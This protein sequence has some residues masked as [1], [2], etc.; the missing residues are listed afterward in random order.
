MEFFD[1]IKPPKYHGLRDYHLRSALTTSNLSLKNVQKWEARVIS[2]ITLLNENFKITERDPNRVLGEILAKSPLSSSYGSELYHAGRALRLESKVYPT[3]EAPLFDAAGKMLMSDK[4]MTKYYLTS[5][6]F[7]RAIVIANAQQANKELPHTVKLSKSDE[8]IGFVTQRLESLDITLKLGAEC[9]GVIMDN[10]ELSIH[11]IDHLKNW[12]DKFTERFNIELACIFGNKLNSSIYPPVDLIYRFWN[13]WDDRLRNF[14]NRMYKCVKIFEALVIGTI[15]Y[16]NPNEVIKTP[17]SF[18]ENTIKDFGDSLSADQTQLIEPVLVMRDLLMSISSMQYLSQL[19]GLYRTW[20]HPIVNPSA[21]IEKVMT[22]GTKVKTISSV[23]PKQI[24]RVFMLKYALWFKRTKSAYPIFSLKE[25]EDN[26]N[27]VYS[28]LISDAPTAMLEATINS[29]FW[30]SLKFEKNIEIPKTYNLSEMVA[31]KAV[32]PNRSGLFKLCNRRGGLYDANMR[33]GVLQWL[34]QEPEACEVFLKRVNDHSLTND[35]C[36]IGLYQKEREENET[37]R[38]FALMS[39]SIRNYIVTSES[40]L[41]EDI[42][43]A[44]PSIT[45]TNSLLDLQKKIYSISH[46]QSLNSSNI[47]FNTYK[48]VTVIVNIDFEKWNLNF[49]RE[50]TFPLFEALGDLYGLPNLYNRTYDIFENSL[51][52][53]A[54]GSY[55]PKINLQTESII[56]EPPLSYIGHLG[57]LE[58][59]RQKGW[60]LFTDC[61]LE[62][63]CVRHKCKYIIMGQGDNQVLA[64]TW[65]TYMLDGNREVNEKGKQSIT[66]QFNNFMSD[67]IETFALLG[68]PIKALETWS[69]EHLF[70]YGKFP[71]LKGIPLSMSLKKICRAY[72]LANEEIMTLDCSL[73]TIQSNAMAACMSDV[74]SY[75]PYVVYKVQTMLAIKSFWD[76]HV[77]LGQGAFNFESGDKWRFTTSSGTKYQYPLDN[78]LNKWDFMIVLSWF[79]KILGGLSVASWFDFLLRGFP[80]RVTSSLTW[81]RSLL[82]SISDIK[83]KETLRSV[84]QTQLNPEKNYTLLIEDPCAL[85][86]VVPVDARASVKQAVQELFDNMQEV[87]NEEFLS[88]FRF[89]K[90]WAKEDFCSALCEGVILHPR[91]LHDVAAATLGGYVDGIVSKVSKASTINKLALRS[92]GRDPGRK[93]VE[94]ERNYML[95]LLWKTSP[96]NSCRSGIEFDCPTR[97]ARE[98][99][100]RSWDKILEGVTVPHPLAFLEFRDCSNNPISFD[101]CDRNYIMVTL[102]EAFCFGDL[103]TVHNLGASPP[104][105]GSETKEK[106]GADPSRQVFGKE[107]LIHRPLRLL[108]VINW[109]VR[110]KSNAE[111][112]IYKL[113]ESVSSLDPENYVSKEMGIT[114]SEAHR[115]RDQ[116]LKH[117]V[118][119]ANMYTLGSHMHIS[120]DTWVKYTRGALNFTINYQSI[121]V[122]V[123]ALIGGHIFNCHD[124]HLI[125]AREYHFHEC[126]TECIEPLSDEFH[127]LPSDKVLSLIPSGFGN[128]YLWVEEASLTLKYRTDPILNLQI[129]EVCYEEYLSYSNKREILTQWVG[130]SIVNDILSGS[131]QDYGPR[132]LDS[133]DYPRVMYKKL[134]VKELWEATALILIAK[135]GVKY[136][137]STGSRVT[138]PKSARELAA[139]DLMKCSSTSLMGLAMFYTWPDKFSEISAYDS[140]AIYPNTCPPTIQSAC[141]AVQANMRNVLRKAPLIAPETLFL[142]RTDKNPSLTIKVFWYIILCSERN[143]CTHCIKDMCSLEIDNLQLMSANVK[144]SMGHEIITR[145]MRSIKV[146]T[147]SLDRVL[148]DSVAFSINNIQKSN[149]VEVMKCPAYVEWGT[150]QELSV[151][152]FSMNRPENPVRNITW[153]YS[154]LL[155]TNSKCRTYEILSMIEENTDFSISSN[156]LILGDGLGTTSRILSNL[157]PDT[158]WVV[159][160]L[161]DSERTIPQCF[162]HVLIPENP[163]PLP[164]VNYSISKMRYNDLSSPGFA[165][166]WSDWIRGGTCWSDIETQDD[167]RLIVENLISLSDWDW[168]IFRSDYKSYAEAS[169]ILQTLSRHSSRVWLFISGSLDV[170][171]LESV[172][173]CKGCT[174]QQRNEIIIYPNAYEDCYTMSCMEL[175]EKAGSLNYAEYLAS[176]ESLEEV[177]GMIHRCDQWFSAVGITHLLS[178]NRLFTAMWWDLQT[179]KIPMSV[180]NLGANKAYYLYFSDLIAL[181]SRLLSLAISMIKSNKKMAEEMTKIAFWK[182]TLSE[183]QNGSVSFVLSRNTTPTDYGPDNLLMMKFVPIL[184]KLNHYHNRWW[185]TVPNEIRFHSNHSMPGFWISKISQNVPVTLP[186]IL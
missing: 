97:Q 75:V 121:L 46:K 145:R 40:M 131:N 136:S 103:S 92:S 60:T 113:L 135:A 83:V 176:I 148:K 17:G 99:R 164:N 44:F 165:I 161:Q 168:I 1:D 84:Y 64:L 22:L 151:N 160:S 49:R 86:L 100:V 58:G 124:N 68:L 36:I 30:D 25:G 98:L 51:M 128:P 85:N 37:P 105:L 53:L 29:P 159:S 13:L 170:E 27:L 149:L 35:E 38:M 4:L 41:S 179:G 156:G 69:S 76:Y 15:L 107:P 12:S 56:L 112:V 24:R 54:D 184:R 182:L 21:G 55:K 5:L 120:T 87:K 141:S 52:Y 167:K 90:E 16:K 119:T 59:L 169:N 9:F 42:L 81:I 181:Q 146:L 139:D 20:G 143:A 166:E 109:F 153:Q 62:S 31:D 101:T 48:D 157:Y 74:S 80:D 66:R 111:Q 95:Y 186:S 6:F 132:L 158:S 14:G 8:A 118:M 150:L 73:A 11:H 2:E 172:V 63:I 152:I 177:T 174:R 138:L 155:P 43:P 45:M 154:S 19:Y 28:L 10:N 108:R 171:R 7:Q 180:K 82:N 144:C 39:H 106:I 89:N 162:P 94:H 163:N 134:G 173:V 117:G 104:Y 91:F 142:E 72:Y 77:L 47:S 185:N 110:P 26:N 175:Y 78:H 32:S 147:A 183:A 71:T 126:C 178:C 125:P 18:L 133:K 140:S 93:I 88:L 116:A 70:L 123:Q 61:G 127:D 23:I 57:G 79:P 115:Y 34:S 65:R 114:G 129:P 50:T 130:H 3:M 102:P 96:T 137:S 67:M 122:I 33:R